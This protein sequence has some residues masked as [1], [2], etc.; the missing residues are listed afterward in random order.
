MAKAKQIE[1]IAE[2]IYDYTQAKDDVC[3]LCATDIV[4]EKWR[5]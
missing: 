4:N 3:T 5:K 1:Q 2:L